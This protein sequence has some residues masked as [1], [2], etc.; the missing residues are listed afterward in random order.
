MNIGIGKTILPWNTK[1][2]A[3]TVTRNLEKGIMTSVLPPIPRFIFTVLEPI[4]LLAGF[5]GVIV[6]P[7]WFVA[8]QVASSPLVALSPNATVVALQLGN[9]YLLLAMVC[10]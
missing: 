5:V 1:G 7:E 6:S 3:P 8:Q 9:I 2:N 10:S 4:S